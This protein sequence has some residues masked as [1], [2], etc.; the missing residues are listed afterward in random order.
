MKILTQEYREQWNTLSKLLFRVLFTYFVLYMLL[1]LLNP[2]FETPFRWIGKEILKI[3]YD[4]EVSGNGSG[5][6]TFAYLTLFVTVILTFIIVIIWSILDR[7][8]KSYNKLL[9]WFCR[10]FRSTRRFAINS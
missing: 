7:S 5:D 6:H 1:M 3:N 9:Y 10:L 8:R 2:L 4:Y